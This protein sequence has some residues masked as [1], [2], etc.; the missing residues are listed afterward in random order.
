MSPPGGIFDHLK[1]FVFN[2]PLDRSEIIF[3]H[4]KKSVKKPFFSLYDILPG[5]LVLPK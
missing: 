4:Q 5:G 2:P 1:A 3:S